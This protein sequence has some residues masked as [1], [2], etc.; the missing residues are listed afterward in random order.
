M[1]DAETA[2]AMPNLVATSDRPRLDGTDSSEAAPA[3]P[4][5]AG[6]FGSLHRSSILRNTRAW[7]AGSIES[8]G[9]LVAYRDRILG[10]I[11]DR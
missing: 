8:G 4:H 5:S 3:S 6:S 7:G 11:R 1:G 9:F 2:P 10:T